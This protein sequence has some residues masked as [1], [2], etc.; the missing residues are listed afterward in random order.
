MFKSIK[1]A[2]RLYMTR[3]FIRVN[4]ERRLE[5]A[6]AIA[7]FDTTNMFGVRCKRIMVEQPDVRKIDHRGRI[8]R[9]K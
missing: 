6:K 7:S 9:Y 1:Q 4:T 5:R 3:R 8:Y 2:Y